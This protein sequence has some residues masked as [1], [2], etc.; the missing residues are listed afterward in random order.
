MAERQK[1]VLHKLQALKHNSNPTR[2]ALYTNNEPIK[3]VI[4]VVWH[5]HMEINLAQLKILFA[6]PLESVDMFPKCADQVQPAHHSHTAKEN[7]SIRLHENRTANQEITKIRAANHVNKP[8]MLLQ[9]SP[10]HIPTQKVV[11]TVT[12]YIQYRKVKLSLKLTLRD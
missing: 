12:M 6:I 2:C 9:Q 1:L 7:L 5:T 4:F 10:L 3:H 11:L 8:G